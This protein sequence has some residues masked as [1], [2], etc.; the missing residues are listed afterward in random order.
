M[1]GVAASRCLVEK[2]SSPLIPT[3]PLKF[4]LSELYLLP[5]GLRLESESVTARQAA[6]FDT[7][8]AK[9]WRLRRGVSSDPWRWRTPAT[10]I[11]ALPFGS[12]PRK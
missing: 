11:A 3:T 8:M 12:Y 10:A 4:S 9:S 5:R 6:I 7:N 1:R 2:S